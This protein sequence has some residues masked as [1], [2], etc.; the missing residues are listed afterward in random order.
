MILLLS[1]S[2]LPLREAEADLLSPPSEADLFIQQADRLALHEDPYWLVLLHVR[3]GLF[4]DR[5]LIDDPKFFLA[6]NGATNPRA[7]LH[8]TLRAILQPVGEV[9]KEHAGCRFPARQAWLAEKLEIPSDLLALPTCP[10]LELILERIQPQALS[11]IYPAAYMNSPASLFG[12]TLLSIKSEH[13]SELLNHAINYA[14]LTQETNGIVFAFKGIFGLYPGHY[15][16]MPYH[17]KVRDYNDISQRDIW[18]FTLSFDKDEIRRMM[19]HVWEVAEV[20]ADYYFFD[21][22]C[23]YQL[24]FLLEAARPG[25]KLVNETRPWVIPLDT[26]HLVTQA[27]LVGEIVYRPSKATNVRHIA[28]QLPP[29]DRRLSRELARGQTTP[30]EA[31]PPEETEVPDDEVARRAKVLDLAAEGLQS[32]FG[33]KKVSREEY[34]PRFRSLL[35]ARSQLDPP[36]EYLPAVPRPGQPDHGHPSARLTMGGGVDDGE[37]FGEFSLRPAYHDLLDPETGFV[38][39]S[40]IQFLG[41]TARWYE[42]DELPEL[43]RLDALTIVSL[44]P[45]DEFFSPVSWIIRTGIARERVEDGDLRHQAFLNTGGGYVWNAGR[46]SMVYALLEADVRVGG[47]GADYA[48]GMGASAGIL[49]TLSDRVKV[50]AFLRG[51]EYP[52]GDTHTLLEAVVRGRYTLRYNTAILL[53]LAARENYGEATTEAQLRLAYYF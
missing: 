4:G 46:A 45:R 8:A 19:L 36:D 35:L 10:E 5:S 21:E 44:S 51:I 31:F 2:A 47:G 27:G 14:A 26:V 38:E 43:Q 23:S 13:A 20:Y 33:R 28:R 25:L 11:L 6:P 1:A 39:G 22:N 41:I 42:N 53:D 9:E 32:Q 7:E 12:H 18:E 37:A 17:R 15:N 40:E 52:I 30:A 3:P 24:L 34:V 16:V 50:Q 48:I 29:D 49:T